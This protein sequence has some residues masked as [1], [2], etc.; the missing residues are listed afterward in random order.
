MTLN[1]TISI[2]TREKM[3]RFHPLNSKA[4]S[5][6]DLF[7]LLFWLQ[8]DPHRPSGMKFDS[9]SWKN[10]LGFCKRSICTNL[11]QR[12]VNIISVFAIP[13]HNS[14]MVIWINVSVAIPSSVFLFIGFYCSIFTI[15]R[16]SFHLLK[17]RRDRGEKKR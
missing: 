7:C 2:W 8:N 14:T 15:Y 9:K 1:C 10:D 4:D 17:N 13:K 6:K 3:R 11:D 16:I 12:R 5:F